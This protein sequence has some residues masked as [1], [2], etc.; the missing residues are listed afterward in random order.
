MPEW[1]PPLGELPSRQQGHS[2]VCDRRVLV[3]LDLTDVDVA[4]RIGERFR[5]LGVELV[6][7]ARPLSDVPFELRRNFTGLAGATAA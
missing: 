1:A 3:D 6:V 2:P 4:V 5:S 7:T